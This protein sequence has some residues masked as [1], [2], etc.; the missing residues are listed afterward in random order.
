M[1]PLTLTLPFRGPPQSDTPG[2]PLG[3]GVANAGVGVLDWLLL[4]AGALGVQ[5]AI[6]R[7]PELN[8]MAARRKMCGTCRRKGG[9]AP[10][11]MAPLGAKG[12]AQEVLRGHAAVAAVAE[13]TGRP[14]DAVRAGFAAAPVPVSLMPQPAIKFRVACAPHFIPPYPHP[15]FLGARSLRAPARHPS[16]PLTG[17]PRR[18]GRRRGGF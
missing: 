17:R 16:A 7:V 14:V 5:P 4:G 11:A 1:H 9:V 12:D 6:N 3:L 15:S 13:A 2:A 8:P 10:V 18:S